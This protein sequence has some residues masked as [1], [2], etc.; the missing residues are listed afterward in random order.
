MLYTAHA[1][2]LLL[3]TQMKK[4]YRKRN[5]SKNTTNLSEHIIFIPSTHGQWRTFLFQMVTYN[6]FI[7]S[8]KSFIYDMST[9]YMYTYRVIC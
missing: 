2:T 1:I 5:R 3:T 8:V 9:L 4:I 7:D 6:F